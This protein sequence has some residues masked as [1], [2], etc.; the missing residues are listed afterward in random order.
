MERSQGPGQE[1]RQTKLNPKQMQLRNLLCRRSRCLSGV[2]VKWLP[3]DG[4][5]DTSLPGAVV[6]NGLTDLL[7]LPTASPFPASRLALIWASLAGLVIASV[8]WLII[9][10]G[11]CL[12]RESAYQPIARLDKPRLTSLPHTHALNEQIQWTVFLD[13][14][15]QFSCCCSFNLKLAKMFI[16]VEARFVRLSSRALL[17]PNRC[18]IRNKNHFSLFH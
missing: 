15:Q 14:V 7:L 3:T 6:R 13:S 5:S 1:P 4:G 2:G 17:L 12:D 9:R 8:G 16:L 18:K 10:N 11:A